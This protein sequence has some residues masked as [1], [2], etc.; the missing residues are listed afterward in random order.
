MTNKSNHV[1]KVENFIEGVPTTVRLY[2]SNGNVLNSNIIPEG[3]FAFIEWSSKGIKPKRTSNGVKFK[4]TTVAATLD[5]FVMINLYEFF[6][7]AGVVS[8]HSNVPANFDNPSGNAGAAYPLEFLKKEVTNGLLTAI[9]DNRRVPFY[10]GN[11]SSNTKDNMTLQG[12]NIGLKGAQCKELFILGSSDHGNY[13]KILKLF[14]SDGTSEKVLIGFA[15]WFLK[16]LSGEWIAFRAPYGLSSQLQ[17]INGNPKLYVQKIK[18]NSSKKL[19]G[20]K[21][22]TQITMHIFAISFLR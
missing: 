5:S 4:K 15:D 19:I 20:I 17:K 13:T 22:P 6:N 7:N 12:Q 10:M 1:L 3:G 8:I 2:N 11:L 16:P 18:L 9:V 14:Y 21:F